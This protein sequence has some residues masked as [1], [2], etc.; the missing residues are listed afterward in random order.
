[1]RPGHVVERVN[2]NKTHS[3]VQLLLAFKRVFPG[4]RVNC[5]VLPSPF[6][7]GCVLALFFLVAQAH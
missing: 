7:R 5:Q 3:G 6:L 2:G 4:D 1:M